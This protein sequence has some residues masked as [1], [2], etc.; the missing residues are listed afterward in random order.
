MPKVY[1]A[2]HAS[3]EGAELATDPAEGEKRLGDYT[4]RYRLGGN[5]CLAG[6]FMGDWLFKD[7]LKP[8][9]LL[10]FNDMAHYTFVKTCT[11]NGLRHPSLCFVDTD[12]DEVLYRRDFGYEDFKRKLS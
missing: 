4:H 5:S 12:T 10:L 2:I 3:A 7:E 1:G 11:F 6:D 9:H 8:G